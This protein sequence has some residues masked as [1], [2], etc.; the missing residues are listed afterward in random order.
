MAFRQIKTPA[1][2]N[3]AVIDTKLDVTAVSGQTALTSL[4][5]PASDVFLVH[6]NAANALR[7]ITASAVI[8]SFTTDD[9]QEGSNNE[10][11][12]NAKAQAAVAQDIADAVA[13][14]ATLRTAADSA[15][16]VVT[17]ALQGELDVT[18]TG[19]GLNTDGT[20]AANGSGNYV[21]TAT[22][23]KDADDK[24]D[25]ALAA[26]DAA[27]KSA[28]AT[29][30][31]NIDFITSNVD[32][33][34]LDSLTEIVNAFQ[35]AD[36]ALSASVTANTGLI[37][38]ETLRAT[39]EEARIEGLVTATQA[40]LDA[41]QVGAGLGASGAYVA[42]ASANYIASATSL[43]AAD[44]ALDSALKAEETART[45]ADTAMQAEVDSNTAKIGSAALDTTATDLSAGLN[46]VHGELNAEVA[47]ATAAEGVISANLQTEVNARG[48]ADT[49]IIADYEAADTALQTE[50]DATQA[51]A[52]LA[53]DGTYVQNTN[54]DYINLA[55]DLNMA[56]R[57]L[58]DN[59]KLVDTAYKAA[60]TAL[61]A[62]LT[63]EEGN[64]DTLQTE[65]QALEDVIG[66]IANTPLDTTATTLGG[67]INEVHGEVNAIEARVTTNESDI[68][69]N[70]ASINNII[71]NTDQAALDSLTEIVAAFQ[72]ADS[73]LTSLVTANATQIDT[74]EASV[75]LNAD[76]SY[77]AHS[78]SNY[79]DSATTIKSALT[80]L[81]T[82]SKSNADALAQEVLDRVAD[83]DAEEAA[84]ISAVSAVQLELDATQ[85]GAGLAADGSYTAEALSNYLSAATDLKDADNKLDAQVKIVADALAAE[86]ST[87]DGEITALDTRVTAEETATA[88]A[89]A[90]RALI[91]TEFANAD[92]TLQNNINTLSGEVDDTQIG[93]GLAADGSYVANSGTNYLGTAT[94]LK[95]ATEKLDAQAKVNAD[96]LAAEILNRTN[97]V[98]AEEARS[99]AEEGRIETKIDNE[100][101]RA[102]GVDATHT[103][104]IATNV[105]DIATN[106]ADIITEAGNRASADAL[107]QTELDATQGGAG[108]DTDGGYTADATTNYLGSATDLFNADVLLDTQIKTVD[109]RIDTLVNGADTA[110]DTLKE[111]GDAF[112]AADQN[113]QGLIT[114]NSTRLT[115]NEADI[116]AL[117]LYTDK[118]NALDTAATTLGAAI[119]EL[120]TDATT[121]AGRVTVNEG[122]ISTNATDIA[123]LETVLGDISQNPLDTTAATFGGAINEI[124][125]ELDAA[126]VEITAT[127]AAVGLNTD[128]TYSA[129]S[130]SNYLDSATT[131]KGALSAIDTQVKQ[132]ADDI[133]SGDAAV[134]SAFQAADTQI[135][136][137]YQ[138]ADTLIQQELD[139]SQ[140]GAGLAANGSYV[141]DAT[142]NYAS[143]ATSLNDA[144][145]KI[146]AAVKVNAD[147]LA[148]EILDRV[149]DVDAEEVRAIAEEGRIEGLV[150]AE[151]TRATGVETALD[152]RLT[153]AEGEITA[154]QAGAGL[155]TSGAYAADATTNYLT[156]ATSLKDADKKLDAAIKAEEA[157]ALLAEGALDTRLTTE[158]GN[159][160]ALELLV[161]S[162]AL[163][164]TATALVGAVNEIHGEVDAV[165][166]RVTQNET[167]IA[168]NLASINTIISNTDP[169]AL[170]SLTEIVAAFQAADSTLTGLVTDNLNEINA[171]ETSLGLN[172]DGTYMAHSGTNYM[173]TATTAKGA[174]ELLD[175]AISAEE[176]A[177]V[178]ADLVQDT[179]I[180]AKLPLAGGT[181]TGALD[182]GSNKIS[183]VTAPTAATDA[184]NKDYVDTAISAQDISLYTTDDLAEG[185]NEYFTPTRAR[186]AVSVNDT[187]AAGAMLT[188]NS[189]TGVFAM[190]GDVSVLELTDVADSDF[191]SKGEY[192]LAVKQDET[193]MELKDITELSF[194][195]PNRITIN[196]DGS[197]TTFALG[198]TTTQS[199]AMVFVGGVVQ[200]PTTHYTI[201]GSAG[202]IT[203]TDTIP[204]GT[205]AVVISHILGSVP[206]LEANSVTM[207][208]FSADIKAFV[209]QSAVSAGTGGDVIDTFDGTAFRSA[210]YVIQVDNGAGAYETREA[211]VVHDGTSAYI[212]EYA[213]VYTGANLIGD[214]SV[215]MNGNNV[216]LTYTTDSGTA[217]VKV[218]STYID[219]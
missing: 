15:Q 113:L 44:V 211:L 80:L 182:M 183:N 70:L 24:L 131:V 147:A 18:Q 104:A 135:I 186:A 90:D 93:A 210:K 141:A 119:N 51:G 116:D 179:A 161:G 55:T 2:A 140:V 107:I 145:K 180:A 126:V 197:T 163:D 199:D 134:T 202:T 86:I 115:T 181:M 65:V 92:T 22:S 28:D 42:N 124:H 167:D 154:T 193:G 58:A 52:G 64:V 29:L 213:L 69:T 23:L 31:T 43:N 36:T 120:H 16:D 37:N 7:K 146:D 84:R 109:G 136:S 40:E 176:A 76:G 168:T 219:V 83:V 158:E 61:D 59:I 9:L 14:E 195:S 164:T 139:A 74:V 48:A 118:G 54:T 89:T 103:A 204:T 174:R 101:T 34:S 114:A 56:D 153:A 77:A 205:Q 123:A 218:I 62:R 33:A 111:I 178:A 13:A 79:I 112:D 198:F 151:V 137:D 95:D 81:D 38:A 68:A 41:T 160:D 203:F 125:G 143:T 47:R 148:Q 39:G 157:R 25:M 27:Y 170:D 133:V 67:A 32:Q 208:K 172:T 142:T 129:H 152:T 156:A 5:T 127:Q 165:E 110:L 96:D 3:Q 191:T 91:R 173:D 105:N 169:A 99:I 66:D 88:T 132:N 144:D 117:E 85:S 100:V 75:G 194:A 97:D 49:Q 201:N 72:A 8:G 50:L 106:A 196:G 121:L 155:E 63:T 209:Q 45:N 187:T 35:T 149:A 166:A 26:M 138:A 53:S 19:A 216:E 185:S 102:T 177:R 17:A 10:Y 190:N 207:D 128:G 11:F 130:G 71:S 159:V 122:D 200:D 1:L 94:S 46:E 215:N 82:Q 98:D 78:G 108:L 171:I 212:T 192:V 21:S 87:T 150:T 217:T 4:N 175:T 57:I 184:A 12:T 214:A 30:Q 162:G 60:D 188:Y 73:T 189:T 206:Y 20:Y 6:D